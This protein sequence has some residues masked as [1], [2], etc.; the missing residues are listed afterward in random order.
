MTFM[1]VQI[2]KQQSAKQWPQKAI[3]DATICLFN[4]TT[5]TNVANNL[6]VANTAKNTFREIS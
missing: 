6:P 1:T 4:D 3:V 2:K 5:V